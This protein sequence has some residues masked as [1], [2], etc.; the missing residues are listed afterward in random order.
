MRLSALVDEFH[1][2]DVASPVAMHDGA[3]VTFV[4]PVGR[5]ILYQCNLLNLV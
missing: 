4:E 2:V 5:D 1:L 3:D